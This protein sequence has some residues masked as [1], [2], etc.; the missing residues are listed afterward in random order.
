MSSVVDKIRSTSPKERQRF[1]ID[2]FAGCFGGL[3]QADPDAFRGKFRKMAATPFA[4]YRGSAALFY[5][6]MAN[7]DDPF[8]NEKTS[9]VWIQGDLHAENFGTYMNNQGVIVFDVND[10]D[11]AYI[12]PFTWDLKRLSASLLLLGYQ[13]AMSDDEIRQMIETVIGSYA[14]Q[15]ARFVRSSNTQ[16]FALTLDNT[17]G[18]LL[19]ILRAARLDT[20][21]ALLERNTVIEDYD[22]RFALD[23]NTRSVD[24][25][26]RARIEEAFSAYLDTIPLAKR[27]SRISYKIKD[28]VARR[29]VGIG[30]AGLP[31]FN[32]LVEGP[33]Q[34]LENDIIIYMKQAQTAA[35]SRVITDPSIKGYFEHD[36]H[37]TVLSQRAL[38]A[39]ADP[40]LGYTTLEGSGG[41]PVGQLVAEVSPYTA[42]LDWEEINELDDI[43]HVLDYLGKAVAKIHC[44]SDTDSDQTLVPFSTDTAINEV[45]SGREGEFVSNMVA[46]GQDYGQVVL[47]DYRLFIDAFRNHMM[48][49]L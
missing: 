7:E 26:G 44:V 33:T 37:R 17:D 45:L 39:Y 3:M 29:G 23:K 49:G 41:Q 35:P 13:K 31:S 16:G 42:D 4:F 28:V 2:T 8:S 36:G 20:R 21:V 32:V 6:D 19:E 48:P 46:F 43:L 18:K 27:Q 12:G 1:I 10:F 47:D 30:S 38:Q 9:R 5:G 22:R 14:S 34:A 15:I 40:W 11:E 25:V 24:G